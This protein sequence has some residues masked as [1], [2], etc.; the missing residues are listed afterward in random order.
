MVQ[1]GFRSFKL[2]FQP[3]LV[4][5]LRSEKNL[6]QPVVRKLPLPLFLDGCH[7]APGEDA[8]LTAD[9]QA[10]QAEWSRAT[11][12]RSS[13]KGQERHPCALWLNC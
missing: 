6:Q 13:M 10:K 5:A 8:K 7:I 9:S 2:F 3:V 11:C 12:D 1:L 4:G